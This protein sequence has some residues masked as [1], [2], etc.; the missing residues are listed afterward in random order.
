MAVLS[1]LVQT[2]VLR[3]ITRFRHGYLVV[4]RQ[5]RVEV[6]GLLDIVGLG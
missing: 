5:D 3:D 6:E 1:L 4:E 2:G